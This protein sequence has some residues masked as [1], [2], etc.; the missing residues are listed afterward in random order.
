V[1]ASR[2]RR[3]ITNTAARAVAAPLGAQRA[4]ALGGAAFRHLEAAGDLV[5]DG[6]VAHRGGARLGHGVDL[7]GLDALAVVEDH[8]AAL[9][10]VDEDVRELGLVL[11]AV[12][13]GLACGCVVCCVL[14]VCALCVVR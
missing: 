9:G 4:E 1:A 12:L 3:G 7:L 8:D 6:V 2:T 10:A 5:L 13:D 11:H 14:C